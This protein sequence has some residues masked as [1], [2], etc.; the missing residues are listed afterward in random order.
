M[1]A[2]AVMVMMMAVT[3]LP[4]QRFGQGGSGPESKQKTVRAQRAEVKR[5]R[6]LLAVDS[7]SPVSCG[8]R[9]ALVKALLDV[10]APARDLVE[11]A[12][13]SFCGPNPQFYYHLAV[14]LDQRGEYLDE[15]LQYAEW[16]SQ[17]YANDGWGPVDPTLLIASIRIKRGESDW[18]ISKLSKTREWNSD[19]FA[20]L[21]LAYERKNMIDE[22]IDAYTQSAGASDNWKAISSSSFPGRLIFPPHFDLETLYRKRYGTLDGLSEK[23]ESARRAAWRSIYVDPFRIEHPSFL[24]TLNGFNWNPVSL[25]DYKGKIVVL[26][27]VPTDYEPALKELKRFQVLSEQYKDRGIIFLVVDVNERFIPREIRRQNALEALKRTG[28]TLPAMMDDNDSVRN[29]FHLGGTAGVVLIDR[30]HARAFRSGIFNDGLQQTTK[31]LD[32]LIQETTEETK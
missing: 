8:T 18:V 27:F 12:G 9:T 31:V 10:G 25:S 22:A 28:V 24:W 13:R 21:G 17:R 16:I 23:L 19:A 2:V 29:A 20:W 3:C 32:Y 26:C 7:S 30:E 5:L 11:A 4:A 14:E 1:T 15:A 6:K